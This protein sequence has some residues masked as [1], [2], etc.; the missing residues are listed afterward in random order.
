MHYIN[1]F[2]HSDKRL[3]GII[4]TNKTRILA[5]QVVDFESW[6]ISYLESYCRWNLIKLYNDEQFLFIYLF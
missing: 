5:L 3:D 1:H 6:M 4:G 2:S